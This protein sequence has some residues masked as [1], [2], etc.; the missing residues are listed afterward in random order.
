M[1][2]GIFSDIE[3][4]D[5]ALD[6]ILDELSDCDLLFNLGD[7]VGDKGDSDKVI[8]RLRFN[9]I[10]SVLGN[11][12]L[13]LVT[14]KSVAADKYMAKILHETEGLFHPKIHVN[15]KNLD[16]IRSLKKTITA[17]F[18][19]TYISF[20]HSIIGQYD[21]NIYFDY[22]DSDNALDLFT[23]SNSNIFFV[24]HSHKPTVVVIGKETCPRIVRI[25]KTTSFKIDYRYRYIIN[26]GSVGAPREKEIKYSYSKMDLENKEITINIKKLYND[27]PMG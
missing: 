25:R 23:K 10:K 5:I 17:K 11:H 18:H 13:E 7:N 19:D 2:I 27:F 15:E 4:N 22:I 1:K 26:P 6:M 24:G 21:Q 9:K 20:R 3:G 12:D 8:E 14:N 16:Y